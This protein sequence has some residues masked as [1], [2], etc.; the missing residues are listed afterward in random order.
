MI[1][2]DDYI[3]EPIGSLVGIRG[4]LLTLDTWYASLPISTSAQPASD[5]AA[6]IAI[7][8]QIPLG[9]GVVLPSH[10]LRNKAVRLTQRIGPS[11]R[12]AT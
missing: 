8:G 6:Q 11:R 10:L 1:V 7:T 3:Y 2:W 5:T 4:G 9:I 12:V